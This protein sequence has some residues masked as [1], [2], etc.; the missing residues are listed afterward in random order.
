[1]SEEYENIY[2]ETKEKMK[3]IDIEFVIFWKE[4]DL[5]WIIK[6]QR[7]K[8]PQNEHVKGNLQID[9]PNDI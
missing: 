8:N 6:H 3:F 2:L 4:I 7:S 5:L 1:M 9:W